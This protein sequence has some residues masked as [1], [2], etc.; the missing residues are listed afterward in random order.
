MFA[1]NILVVWCRIVV[2]TVSVYIHLSCIC[3]KT[4][5][6]KMHDGDDD[7]CLSRKVISV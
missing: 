6:I 3:R 2:G 5:M 4:M 1:D 7:E